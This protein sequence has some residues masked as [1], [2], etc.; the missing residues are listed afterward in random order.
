MNSRG[1]FMG[2]MVMRPYGP[3]YYPPTAMR[4]PTHQVPRWL[5][6]EAPP[7]H[8]RDES[9]ARSPPLYDEAVGGDLSQGRDLV[10]DARG[11]L[12]APAGNTVKLEDAEPLVE[13]PERN[14]WGESPNQQVEVQEQVD[15]NVAMDQINEGEQNN[16]E[17]L[18][19]QNLMVPERNAVHEL[20]QNNDEALVEQNLVIPECEAVR[21]LAQG[22]R[23]IV[24]QFNQT[25]YIHPD[26]I[27][28]PEGPLL[29]IG[30]PLEFE[31]MPPTSRDD[32]AD[33]Y[34]ADK[35]HLGPKNTSW[36]ILID[37]GAIHFSGRVI[38]HKV[39]KRLWMCANCFVELGI[40]RNDW[41]IVYLHLLGR[42]ESLPE[43]ECP[44]QLF[45]C[46]NRFQ[47]GMSR[48]ATKLF[49]RIKSK[50]CQCC[51]FA[52]KPHMSRVYYDNAVFDMNSRR[53]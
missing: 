25:V 38:R 1:E 20:E 12:N 11:E 42:E 21:E 23:R 49:Q 34:M 24:N 18:V 13:P 16:D 36:R 39:F 53:V 28:I 2:Y 27:Q 52:L 40:P 41:E 14:A 6:I 47:R 35:G 29:P 48:G 46:R 26:G 19:E 50:E 43:F 51:R 10:D 9:R 37:G 7:P 45:K 15:Q 44:L 31:M 30:L 33:F 8:S 5:E 4:V 3:C 17:A 32:L 22:Y